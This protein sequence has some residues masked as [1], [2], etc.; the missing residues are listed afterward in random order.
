MNE[1]TNRKIRK[2]PIKDQVVELGIT[3]STYN[4]S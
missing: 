4:S 3:A 2:I 1:N